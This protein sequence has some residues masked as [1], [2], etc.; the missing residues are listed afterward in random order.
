[1]YFLP[2]SSSTAQSLLPRLHLPIFVPS[3]FH[4][5]VF[6]GILKSV[7]LTREWS[8]LHTYAAEITAC[9]LGSTL[10]CD[11][12]QGFESVHIECVFRRSYRLLPEYWYQVCPH[13]EEKSVSRC[14]Y[15]A[16]ATVRCL[17]SLWQGCAHLGMSSSSYVLKCEV[18]G[19]CPR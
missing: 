2:A 6:A 15:A 9:R 17:S 8:W 4:L 1:M 3:L 12:Q 18:Y 11:V 19:V 7:Q 5:S 14:A 10:R 13:P 16:T